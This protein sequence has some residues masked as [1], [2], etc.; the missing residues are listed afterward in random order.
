MK[1]RYYG[2]ITESYV[3]D[4]RVSV[5]IDYYTKLH[6]ARYNVSPT[7]IVLNEEEDAS[8]WREFHQEYTIEVGSISER[9][10]Y[11]GIPIYVPK[12]ESNVVNKEN[13]VEKKLTLKDIKAINELLKERQE[14]FR[15]E[16]EAE[17]VYSVEMCFESSYGYELFTKDT[18]YD[19]IMSIRE[20]LKE[21]YRKK[22]EKI[23]LELRTL[24]IDI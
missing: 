10:H 6:Y 3:V 1:I 18:D 11:R 15:K 8:L 13:K 4:G 23:E 9:P 22:M 2:G 12:L 16:K 19:L 7:H 14:C 17:N 24:G 20:N 21:H 5:A